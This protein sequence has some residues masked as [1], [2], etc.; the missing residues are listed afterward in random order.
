MLSN[1]S[2]RISSVINNTGSS[3]YGWRKICTASSTGATGRGLKINVLR[4]LRLYAI[5]SIAIVIS[6]RILFSEQGQRYHLV[7]CDVDLDLLASVFHS[8]K[9][10]KI[11]VSEG[12]PRS[13]TR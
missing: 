3:H 1:R 5:P 8:S 9:T 12:G 11:V 6:D 13:R 7:F 4:E 10:V 2:L